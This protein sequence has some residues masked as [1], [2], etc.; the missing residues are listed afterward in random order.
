MRS[1]SCFQRYLQKHI[2]LKLKKKSKKC[3]MTSSIDYVIE[4][5]KF[6]KLVTVVCEVLASLDFLKYK[7]KV[8]VTL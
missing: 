7:F 4:L 5:K 2:V 8:K 3:K 6:S 1:S